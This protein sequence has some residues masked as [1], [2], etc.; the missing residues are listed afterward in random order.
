M[1]DTGEAAVG[2]DPELPP[3]EESPV[4][5][6]PAPS[7][8]EPAP[9]D[10]ADSIAVEVD[11]PQQDAEP[12]EEEQAPSSTAPP[13]ADEPDSVA[14]EVDESHRNAEPVGEAEVP[15]ATEP[16]LADA[17]DTVAVEIDES[18]EDGEPHTTSYWKPVA[19]P[20][21]A[22]PPTEPGG[23]I[24]EEQAQQAG[25]V[26]ESGTEG[27]GDEAV[28]ETDVGSAELEQRVQHPETMRAFE[29]TYAVC[30]GETGFRLT[31]YD[32]DD[33]TAY[34]LLSSTHAG[35]LCCSVALQRDA[36]RLVFDDLSE[37]ILPIVAPG[38]LRLP[39]TPFVLRRE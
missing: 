16:P 36:I 15:Q 6:P 26:G 35:T 8:T 29:G 28:G 17:A 10:V 33:D 3:A 18:Q 39:G 27:G 11:E 14:V 5:E 38:A 1:A 25:V 4:G 19:A 34:G 21:P 7:P 22:A 2:T 13:P 24:R 20:E 23:V 12:V 37:M 32:A 9:A 30:C 31:I